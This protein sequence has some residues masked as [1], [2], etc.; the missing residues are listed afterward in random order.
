MASSKTEIC[1]MALG[2]LAVSDEIQNFDTER[3]VQA[4]ACRRF[5][6]PTVEEVLRDFAWP[7]AGRNAALALVASNPTTEWG[8]S[9]RYPSDCLMFRKLLSGIR[10]DAANT[11]VPYRVLSD[12]VGGL[13]YADLDSAVSEYTVRIA[14]PT[15]FPPD[16]VTAVSYLLAVK[17]APRVTGGDPFKLG[18][19]AAQKYILFLSKAEK[20]AANE[21]QPDMQRE[22]EFVRTRGGSDVLQKTFLGQSIQNFPAQD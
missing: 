6:D 9:Y 13:I 12:A 22:S 19:A 2:H 10:T 11:R 14:D 17:I 4:Q 7:F 18:D 21:E 3:T 16:F 20:N 15:R 5:Y 8:F 1:N